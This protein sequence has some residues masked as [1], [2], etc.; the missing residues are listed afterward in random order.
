MV[1][2][3][4]EVAIEPAEVGQRLDRVLAARVPATSR[5]TLQRWIEEGRVTLAGRPISAKDKARSGTV[6]RVEPGPPPLS[7]ALPEAIPL[8]ILF[9][10]EHLIVLHKPA[11]LVVHPAAGHASGTLVNALLHH[12][13]IER[14]ED[15]RRPGV[16]HRLDKDTSGVMV[17]TCTEAARAGLS[18]LFARHEIERVYEAICL[19]HP[20]AEV[21]YETLIGR[22]P[23]ER[24]RFSSKVRSGKRA[25]THVR[26]VRTL[27]GAALVRCQLETGRTHQI[28]VH[29][30]DHGFP[31]LGDSVYGRV[32]KDALLREVSRELGRQALHARSLGFVHPITGVALRFEVEPPEDFRRALERLTPPLG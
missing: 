22:H 10:D 26:R 1:G 18:A 17:V 19:G 5:A 16:V 23:Q 20:A 2:A 8:D 29:L 12:A 28:R 32:S 21:R 7:E 30:A 14:G 4:Y 24:K 25:V 31:L 27:L 11:G 13:E 6:V 15:P 9:Q 3:A